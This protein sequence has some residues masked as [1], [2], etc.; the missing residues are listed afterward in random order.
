[1]NLERFVAIFILL[2]SVA[3]PA[4]A[5]SLAGPID[6]EQM[7]ADAELIVIGIPIDNGTSRQTNGGIVTEWSVFPQYVLRGSHPYEPLRVQTMGGAIDG[8]AMAGFPI[9]PRGAPRIMFLRATDGGA[10][11]PI[12][13]PTV[14]FISVQ[15]IKSLSFRD[16]SGAIVIGLADEQ[17][18]SALADAVAGSPFVIK[19][20]ADDL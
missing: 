6:Y 16:G 14:E 1:M 7:I 20:I 18:V 12:W 2:L 15:R 3:H 5:L 13:R 4:S 10:C 17:L 11:S 19:H 8:M 9:R